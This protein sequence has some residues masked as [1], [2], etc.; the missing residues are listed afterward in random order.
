M[1]PNQLLTRLSILFAQKKAGNN[2]KKLNNEIRQIIYSFYSS[3]NM[4]KT[5]CNH[6]INSI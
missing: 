1:T 2:S 6:L 4:S 3:K 5:I